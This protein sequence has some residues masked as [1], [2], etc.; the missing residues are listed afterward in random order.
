M[1]MSKENVD[2]NLEDYCNEL[3][4]EVNEGIR[5]VDEAIGGKFTCPTLKLSLKKKIRIWRPWSTI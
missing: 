3:D 2:L 4:E 1:E 5:M